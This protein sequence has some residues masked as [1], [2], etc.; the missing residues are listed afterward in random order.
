MKVAADRTLRRDVPRLLAEMFR[1]L[2]PD[3]RL[4]LTKH[5][6]WREIEE[7]KATEETLN[8]KRLMAGVRRGLKD[9]ARGRV[10]RAP[11][12]RG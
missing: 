2:S 4:E 12:G 6:S 11:L 3:E 5:L 7:W 1:R 9:E 10:R 8:D